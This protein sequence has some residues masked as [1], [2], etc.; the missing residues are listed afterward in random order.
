MSSPK[1]VLI[2]E[3]EQVLQDV[4][5]LVLTSGGYT[6]HTASNGV[7]G[8]EK[9]KQV[10]PDLVLLDIFMPELCRYHP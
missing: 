4:Y 3:D 6:L 7:E 5:K 10:K 1:T 9:I 8:L 2:V